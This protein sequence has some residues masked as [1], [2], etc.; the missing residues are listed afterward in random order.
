MILVK[1]LLIFM[2]RR[3]DSCFFFAPNRERVFEKKPM[4]LNYCFYKYLI[5]S[6]LQSLYTS[7]RMWWGEGSLLFYPSL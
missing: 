5:S 7:F 1:S 3:L 2:E 6:S 4:T